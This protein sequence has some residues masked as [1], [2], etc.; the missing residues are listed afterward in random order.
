MAVDLG[1]IVARA[2]AG[3]SAAVGELFRL[4]YV[5]VLRFVRDRVTDPYAA[6]DITS[7]IFIKVIAH[8]PTVDYL[9]EKAW[10]GWLRQIARTTIVDHHRAARCRPGLASYD[11]AEDLADVAATGETADPETTVVDRIDVMTRLADLTP[12]QRQVLACR[13]LRDLNVA[14]TAAAVGIHRGTVRTTQH[15]ALAHLAHQNGS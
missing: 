6:E 5:T 1:A 3:D 9:G 8:L 11:V 2:A 13:Y 7:E 12:Q 10:A 14:D 4:H 15:R